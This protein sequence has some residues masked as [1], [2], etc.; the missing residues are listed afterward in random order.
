[1]A[2][3]AL[4][5]IE[6]RN[7]QRLLL[8]NVEREPWMARVIEFVNRV[9]AP[10]Q[11]PQVDTVAVKRIWAEIHQALLAI[12]LVN[13]WVPMPEMALA[14]QRT[15]LAIESIPLAFCAFL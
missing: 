10:L 15:N 4:S 11:A 9:L 1:M 5:R 8:D 12:Q 13:A 2:A 7:L 14:I 6:I 3:I